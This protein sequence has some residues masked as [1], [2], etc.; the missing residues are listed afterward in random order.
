MVRY[1]KFDKRTKQASADDKGLF[2]HFTAVVFNFHGDK[3]II[4][5][6][7]LVLKTRKAYA[8]CTSAWIIIERDI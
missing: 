6:S 4:T 5:S 1:S 2:F 7:L 3:T 8:A